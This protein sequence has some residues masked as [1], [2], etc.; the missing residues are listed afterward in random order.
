[1][2]ILMISSEA[3]PFAKSGGLGDAVS[4]LAVALSGLGHDVRLL[5]PR[6]YSIAKEGLK[7]LEGPMGVPMGDS[8]RWTEVFSALLPNSHVPVYFLEYEAFFGR[9]GVYGASS[10]EEYP[11]NPQRF[12]L[13]SRAA[14][15]LCRK[16]NWIR[17]I[18]HAHDWPTALIP[19]YLSTLE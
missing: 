18:L 2:K 13:L 1:M 12:A 15:Q 10:R 5:I 4:A 9:A 11:D 3:V 19:V 7:A 6:Y 17:D 14:F 16:L 8:E